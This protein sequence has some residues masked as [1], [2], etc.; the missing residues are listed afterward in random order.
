MIQGE[1]IQNGDTRLVTGPTTGAV[2]L[3]LEGLRDDEVPAERAG[4]GADTTFKVPEKVRENDRLYVMRDVEV[5][6]LA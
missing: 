6:E 3:T 4:K 5:D 1:P 2:Y